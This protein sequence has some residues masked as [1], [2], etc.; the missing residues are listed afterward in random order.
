MAEIRKAERKKARLRLGLVAPSG[1]G[2]TASSLL[3]AFGVTGDWSKVGMIDTEAGSGELYVGET[4]ST[5]DGLVKVEDYLYTRIEPPFTA[6]KYLDAIK[7][8]QKALGDGG[9]IIIDSLSHAWSGAGGLLDKQGS[10]A[11]KSG[12]SY[13]AWRQVTPEHNQLVEAILQS[14]CHIIAT[15][16][17]KIEYVLETNDKGKQVP[18]KVGL[19]PV[20]REG[21]EYEFTVVFDIDMNHVA[22]VSKDRSN[23]FDGVFVKICPST[24]ESLKEWLEKGVE[25]KELGLDD[26]LKSISEAAS[27]DILK[28]EFAK[29]KD[30]FKNNAD[31][32]V[33]IINAKDARKNELEPPKPEKKEKTPVNKPAAP[34]D[35]DLESAL[36]GIK[37]GSFEALKAKLIECKTST[38]IQDFLTA[39]DAAVKALPQVD[40]DNLI[41]IFTTHDAKV[42]G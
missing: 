4:F 36:S 23:L 18:K 39:N 2:K 29:A 24:G 5:N 25:V 28:T 6:V 15:M 17:A 1:A 11:D 16:R 19:A 32:L 7:G 34:V 30:K 22:S 42:R 31:D 9:C 37:P 10:I 41:E 13:T 27:L 14:N 35:S 12:N 33:K 21:M 38:E 26:F 3:L 20:Q 40:Y 8:M